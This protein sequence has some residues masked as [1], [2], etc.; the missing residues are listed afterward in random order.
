M[1]NTISPPRPLA[2]INDV[3]AH[4]GVPVNTI[5]KWSSEGTGPAPMRVGRHLRWRWED[6]E[7]FDAERTAERANA[8]A[9]R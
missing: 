1:G 3:A 7:R 8:K 9:S 2:D 5:Y 4:Y 6:I